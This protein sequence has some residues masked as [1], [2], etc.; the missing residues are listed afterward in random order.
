MNA[1][2]SQSSDTRQAPATLVFFSQSAERARRL[3]ECLGGIADV[4]HQTGDAACFARCAS[5]LRPTLAFIDF[6]PAPGPRGRLLDPMAATSVVRGCADGALLVGVG[7][8]TDS[9]TMLA[10]MRAGVVDFVDLDEPDETVRAVVKRLLNR[11]D[12]AKATVVTVTSARAGVG[13]STFAAHFAALARSGDAQRATAKLRRV[14]LLDLGMPVGDGL[15]YTNTSGGF[16]LADAVH[17]LSRLDETLV[18]TALPESPHGLS[19]LSLPQELARMRAVQQ[20]DALALVER[21][22]SYFDVLVIDLG[23]LGNPD[24][25]ASLLKRADSAFVLAEQGVAAVVSLKTLLDDY[26]A[27]GVPRSALQLVVNRHDPRCGLAADQLAARFSLPLAGTLPE[28]RVALAAAASVGK[29]LA[30]RPRDRYVRSLA[31]LV[32]TAL[33]REPAAGHHGVQDAAGTGVPPAR[34][35]LHWLRQWRERFF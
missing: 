21:L 35:P 28:H 25:G 16:D 3:A 34:P 30:L 10:A 5:T 22:R 31:R 9:A 17:S 13:A 12:A 19:V 23:G 8:A 32:D 29:L 7:S 18:K 15:L 26:D 4:Q 1:L 33:R 6:K 14:A 2:P 11:N 24:L 27:R 20:A